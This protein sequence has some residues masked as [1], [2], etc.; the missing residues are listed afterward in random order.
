MIILACWLSIKGKQFR[1]NMIMT[2]VEFDDIA[3]VC[4]AIELDLHLFNSHE[5]FESFCKFG[6]KQCKAKEV[7]QEFPVRA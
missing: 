5:P 7:L 1:K 3:C 2:L 6:C 4:E